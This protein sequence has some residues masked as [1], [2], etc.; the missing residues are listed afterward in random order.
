[1]NYHPMNNER[2]QLEWVLQKWFGVG[3]PFVIIAYCFP[4]VPDR[5]DML[6]PMEESAAKK[7]PSRWRTPTVD[8]TVTKNVAKPSLQ[9][10]PK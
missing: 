4:A 6:W 10:V 5:M 8:Y 7:T 9:S 3:V 1:M 2:E